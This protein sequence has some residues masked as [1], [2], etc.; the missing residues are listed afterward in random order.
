MNRIDFLKQNNNLGNVLY[1]PGALDDIKLITDFVENSTLNKFIFTDYCDVKFDK[2]RVSN[3]LS[4]HRHDSSRALE[5]KDF[6]LHSWRDFWPEERGSYE[7]GNPE[8]AYGFKHVFSS[9]HSNKQ[10]EIIYLGTEAIKTCEILVN[11]GC[12]PDIIVLQD[13]GTGGNWSYFGIRDG[14]PSSLYKTL[15]E[16]GSLP[17]YLL[18]KADNQ[19]NRTWPGYLQVT[20]PY[21]ILGSQHQNERALFICED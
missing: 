20:D 5:P 4:E 8:N 3:L 7:F 12:K 10:F 19:E 14:E 15:N 11:T 18:A 6:H 9:G 13:H 17:K 21:T 1:Y 2:D 16:K